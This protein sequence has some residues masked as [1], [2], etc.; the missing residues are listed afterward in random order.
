MMWRM[1]FNITKCSPA[2]S[3]FQAVGLKYQKTRGFLMFSGGIVRDEW[4][5]L[6]NNL[7]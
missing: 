1:S 2:I 5:E 3:P 4:H 6:V 7:S